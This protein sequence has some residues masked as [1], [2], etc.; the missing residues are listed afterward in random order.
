M[1]DAGLHAVTG[2]FGY[3]GQYIA[4]RL[5]AQGRTVITLTNSPD[6]PNP[7]G[8]AV[9]AN[10][11]HFDEPEKLAAALRGVSARPP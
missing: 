6:R 8:S 4:R 2:A 9:Q 5:L 7:C 1:S 11:F 10:P 3:S